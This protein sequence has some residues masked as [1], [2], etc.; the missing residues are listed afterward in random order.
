MWGNPRHRATQRRECL[1]ATPPPFCFQPPWAAPLRPLT[2]GPAAAAPA[3]VEA[4]LRLANPGEEMDTA[5]SE[6][7]EGRPQGAA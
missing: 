4:R 6:A 2:A 5:V 7:L 1:S 3:L